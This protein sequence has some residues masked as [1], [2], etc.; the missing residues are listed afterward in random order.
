MAI[1]KDNHC[2][3]KYILLD[4]STDKDFQEIIKGRK[5][6]CIICNSNTAKR[7]RPSLFGNNI[8]TI[9]N[10]MLDNVFYINGVF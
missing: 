2:R 8:I 4:N 1:L 3:N 5:V 10:N 6:N 7:F 9:N